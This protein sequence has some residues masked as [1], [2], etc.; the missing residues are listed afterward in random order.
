M[1]CNRYDTEA[2]VGAGFSLFPRGVAF[3]EYLIDVE[4]K[5]NQSMLS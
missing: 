2:L 5:T 3:V 4:S 1:K